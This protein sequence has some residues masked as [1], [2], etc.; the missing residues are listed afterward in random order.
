MNN[1]VFSKDNL[2]LFS[3]RQTYLHNP[4]PHYFKIFIWEWTNIDGLKIVNK[5]GIKL[6]KIPKQVLSGINKALEEF[7]YKNYPWLIECLVS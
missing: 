7:K 3:G 6:K 2:F 1:K 4:K 5:K